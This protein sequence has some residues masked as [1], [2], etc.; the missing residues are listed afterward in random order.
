MLPMTAMT[1]H[2][3]RVLRDIEWPTAADSVPTWLNRL[4]A[5]DPLLKAPAEDESTSISLNAYQHEVA[6]LLLVRALRQPRRS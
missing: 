5:S 6:R 2:R 1:C 3:L 4:L